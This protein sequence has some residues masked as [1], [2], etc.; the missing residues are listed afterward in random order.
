MYVCVSLC[1]GA[2]EAKVR[3]AGLTYND[4]LKDVTSPEFN[5]EQKEFCSNVSVAYM[6]PTVTVRG[7][8][9]L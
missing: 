6:F 9:S 3:I 8:R 1:S 7:Y 4:K 2:Y 5:S